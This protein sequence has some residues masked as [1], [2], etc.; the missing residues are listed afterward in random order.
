MSFKMTISYKNRYLF[1]HTL[2][3]TRVY[4]IS[5]KNRNTAGFTLVIYKN[6]NYTCLFFLKLVIKIAMD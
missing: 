1:T 6:R 5:Y 3:F 4:D 2:G